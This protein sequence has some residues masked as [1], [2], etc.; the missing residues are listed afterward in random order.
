[1]FLVLV[2]LP[3]AGLAGVVV[4]SRQRQAAM[5]DQASYRHR[6]ALRVAQKGL[7]QAEYLLK[8][9][10]GGAGAPSS[11][12]RVRFYAEISRALWKYLGDKLNIPPADF[13]VEGAAAELG[14]RSVEGGTVQ[15]LRSMLESCDMARFAPTSVDQAAMQRTYDEAKRV[16]VDIE[17]TLKQL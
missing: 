15:A 3:L 6:R 13:S 16:I 5:L 17:R 12:Q 14:R 4:W 7:K 9:K 2:V 1:M 11:A 10:G 8:E